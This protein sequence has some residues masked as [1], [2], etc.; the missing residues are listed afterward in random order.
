M[1]SEHVVCSHAKAD[2]INQSQNLSHYQHDPRSYLSTMLRA[3][4]IN[5]LNSKYKSKAYPKIVFPFN[6]RIMI[7]HS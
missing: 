4:V 5:L 3:V 1:G 2:T 6:N 7:I